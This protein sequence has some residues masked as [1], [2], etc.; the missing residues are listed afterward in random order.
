M[1]EFIER[2]DRAFAHPADG[3]MATAAMIEALAAGTLAEADFI[4]WVRLRIANLLE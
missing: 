3:L 2:N 4:E 1:R